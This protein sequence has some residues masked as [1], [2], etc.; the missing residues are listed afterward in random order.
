MRAGLFSTACH[1]IA[2]LS[3]VKQAQ[4]SQ[5]PSLLLLLQQSQVQQQ[6]IERLESQQRGHELHLEQV[7]RRCSDDL[8]H[9]LKP[10]V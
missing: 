1:T 9:M 4:S 10:R 7:L 5:P 8:L 3:L 6:L 2:Q